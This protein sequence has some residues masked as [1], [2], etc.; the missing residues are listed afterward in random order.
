M[1]HCPCVYIVDDDQAVLDSICWLMESVGINTRAFE[2]ATALLGQVG[3]TLQIDRGCLIIDAGLPAMSGLDLQ[4]HL[5][6][7]GVTMP[8]IFITGYGHVQEAI[9]AIKAGAVDYIEKPFSGDLLIER[10]QRAIESTASRPPRQGPR[11]KRPPSA[12]QLPHTGQFPM[13]V[14]FAGDS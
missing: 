6:R 9:A 2:S 4:T 5:I 12:R 8:V 14:P 3:D 1:S 11:H 7:L 13:P 10:V